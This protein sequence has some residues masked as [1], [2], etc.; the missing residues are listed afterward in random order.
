MR[1]NLFQN[2]AVILLLSYVTS[3][4]ARRTENL[5]ATQEA[6]SNTTQYFSA[7]SEWGSDTLYENYVADKN[8]KAAMER[9]C[10]IFGLDCGDITVN[11]K[12][13]LNAKATTSSYSSTITLYANAFSFQGQLRHP[14]WLAAIIEHEHIHKKQ[15]WY[16]RSLVSGPQQR[17]LGDYTYDAGL[18]IEAWSTMRDNFDRFQLTCAMQLEV[19]ENI[20]RFQK[21]LTLNGQAPKDEDDEQKNYSLPSTFYKKISDLCKRHI[22]ELK[23]NLNQPASSQP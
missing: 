4:K 13:N 5:S 16:I 11:P 20:Y 9:A 10:G 8:Y 17:F 19:E 14:G 18:E 3:C 23:Q 15:S 2:Y 7:D 12:I 22:W 1:T 21:I 6:P